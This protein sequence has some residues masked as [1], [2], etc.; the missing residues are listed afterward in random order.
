MIQTA[1]L[2]GLN[3]EGSMTVFLQHFILFSLIIFIIS[4][5]S[6]HQKLDQ[7][8][9]GLN[10]R[11]VLS[12]FGDPIEKYRKQGK[13]YWVFE[14][15]KKAKN[16]E[17]LVYKHIFIFENGVLVDKTYTRSFTTEELK[18]FKKEEAANHQ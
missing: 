5:T 12:Q 2:T 3:H 7:T 17:W 6:F 11:Q 15:L 14:A 10:K 4:C 1:S 8:P 13:D 16:K 18:E 9:V